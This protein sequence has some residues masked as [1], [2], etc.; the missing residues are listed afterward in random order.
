MQ[1]GY[2]ELHMGIGHTRA[3]DLSNS[4]SALSQT[5]GLVTPADQYLKYDN[6]TSFL[7]LSLNLR[8]NLLIKIKA[9][10]SNAYRNC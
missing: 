6:L 3:L 9:L 7:L 10:Q 1:G 2:F 5:Q 4:E 8:Y